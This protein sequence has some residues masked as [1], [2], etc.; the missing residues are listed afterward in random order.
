MKE[1]TLELA[2]ENRRCKCHVVHRLEE[3]NEGREL[4]LVKGDQLTGGL[5]DEYVSR[6]SKEYELEIKRLDEEFEK[7]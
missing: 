1:E 3:L 6:L 4:V 2:R 7:I 5:Y